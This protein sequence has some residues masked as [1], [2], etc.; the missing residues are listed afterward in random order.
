MTLPLTPRLVTTMCAVGLAA[1]LTSCGLPDEQ[2]SQVVHDSTVPYDLLAPNGLVQGDVDAGESPP[3]ETPVVFWLS[4]DDRLTPSD[5][6][7]TCDDTP[8]AVVDATEALQLGLVSRLADD[9]VALALEAAEGMGRFSPYGLAMTKD[10][11]WA[12]L[13]ISSLAAAIELEDRNQLML[14]FTDNLPEAIRAFDQGRRPVYTDEPRRDLFTP[15]ASTASGE[16]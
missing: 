11:L 5:A 10:V 16:G 3:K 6:G 15:P 4:R 14:G 8:T 9:V 13:E 1:V 12:N 2:R 7:L